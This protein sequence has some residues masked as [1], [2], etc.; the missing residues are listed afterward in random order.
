ME[1]CSKSAC[2][3]PMKQVIGI[4]GHPEKDKNSQDTQMY[5]GSCDAVL[6]AVG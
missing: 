6:N 5:G 2:R 1:K 4:G 3:V